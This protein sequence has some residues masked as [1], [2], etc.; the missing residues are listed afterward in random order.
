MKHAYIEK[1]FQAKTMAMIKT[2]NGIIANYQAQGFRLTLRQ[3]YYQHVARGLIENTEQ[4]YKKLGSIIND[5]RLAGLLDWDA[6]EDR[7]RNLKALSL[8]ERP[9]QIIS[10][11]RYSYREDKW[12]TQP[13]RCEVW[14]EKDAL[15]GVI[16]GV[17]NRYEVPY[18]A[19]RGYTSQSEMRAAAE[20]LHAY[21][22]AGQDVTIIHLGDHDPSGIDMTRDI[23]D[24]IEMFLEG[25]RCDIRR[26][27][28]NM[29]QIRLY[30]PPP[31]PAKST[32]SRFMDYQDKFGESSWELDALEPRIIADLIERNIL[33][34]RDTDAWNEALEEEQTHKLQLETVERRWTDVTNFLGIV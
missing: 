20:R 13:N 30:S 25:E 4:S 19:C 5:A 17:C 26:I 11:A 8:W 14:V 24:R 33:S 1:N 21:I 18:F 15:V 34:L 10:A 6:I 2:A 32:D 7:T 28:L 9:S 27:A 12:K 16:E 31:N 29:D 22:D 23:D 3:L